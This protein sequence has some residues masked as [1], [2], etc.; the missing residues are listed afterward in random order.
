MAG[1][2]LHLNFLSVSGEFP[3]FA[4][5]RRERA[6]GE[7]ANPDVGIFAYDLPENLEDLGKRK[8]YLVSI[9]P[10]DGFIRFRISAGA[11]IDLTR[12]VLFEALKA[13]SLDVCNPSECHVPT[14]S[15]VKDL[16]FC[17]AEHPEG[18]ERVAL[19]AYYLGANRLF[20]FLVDFHFHLREGQ[21]FTRRVQQLSLSL[22]ENHRRNR[23]WSALHSRLIAHAG[24]DFRN[25]K[26]FRDKRPS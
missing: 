26:E 23:S 3:L 14:R 12:R 19:Q 13:K 4:V 17:M 7:G 5:F 8:D 18:E 15:F 22:D 11:K 20:G 6:P 9:H 10:T 16:Q 25:V 2:D 1:Y 24:S 21:S